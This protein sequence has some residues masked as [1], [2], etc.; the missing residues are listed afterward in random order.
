VE[1]PEIYA[2]ADA[3]L[4]SLGFGRRAGSGGE[5]EALHFA[6]HGDEAH[7]AAS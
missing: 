3:L 7:L 1:L 2:D 4:V 6:D 5:T